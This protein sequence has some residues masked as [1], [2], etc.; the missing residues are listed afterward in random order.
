M[1][2]WQVESDHTSWMNK[3]KNA[4]DAELRHQTEMMVR[5]REH[6]AELQRIE[7]EIS[8]QRLATLNS[9]EAAAKDE[10]ELMDR[11]SLVPF[12]LS[13]LQAQRCLLLPRCQSG[14]AN[15]SVS[16]HFSS[17]VSMC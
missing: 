7:E 9:L 10:M 6:L 12:C 16:G 17:F 1:H 3:H 2:V 5:E 15:D 8:R 4:S 13:T 11:V 14:Y